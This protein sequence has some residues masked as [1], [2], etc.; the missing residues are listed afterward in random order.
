MAS[1]SDRRSSLILFISIGF[2]ITTLLCTILISLLLMTGYSGKQSCTY[3]GVTY[4]HKKG[5]TDSC[6]SCSCDDGKVVCTTMACEE[7]D[8]YGGL[9]LEDEEI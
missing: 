5:F 9:G 3:N 7:E 4:E 1:Y 8:D 2:F 6:N